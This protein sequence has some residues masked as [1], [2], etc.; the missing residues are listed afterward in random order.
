MR[1]HLESHHLRGCTLWLISLTRD[2]CYTF[3][4]Q[5]WGSPT[6]CHLE[7]EL[8]HMLS[9]ALSSSVED[10]P[11]GLQ[12][13]TDGITFPHSFPRSRNISLN[14]SG[15]MGENGGPRSP[16]HLHDC[17]EMHQPLTNTAVTEHCIVTHSYKNTM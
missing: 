10:I 12:S 14:N 16:A 13:H 8:N 1:K 6:P 2:A 11:S 4:C 5:F 15:T 17:L 7:M 3:W 9:V